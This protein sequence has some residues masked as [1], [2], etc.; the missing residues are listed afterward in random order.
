MNYTILIISFFL[1][2]MIL[3][4][5]DVLGGQQNPLHY[6][7]YH[8]S[9]SKIVLRLFIKTIEDLWIGFVYIFLR[10][11]LFGK[12]LGYLIGVILSFGISR[13]IGGIIYKFLF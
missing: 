11:H 4:L 7:P 1:S 12:G 3:T 10:S 5:V 2:N 13:L 6:K 8:S 9:V